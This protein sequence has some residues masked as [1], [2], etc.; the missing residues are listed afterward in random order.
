[1]PSVASFVHFAAPGTDT[2]PPTAPTGLTGQGAI[3]SAT[4][5][6]TASTDNTGVALYN[7]HRSTTS[8]FLPSAPTASASRRRPAFTDT[9]V[10]AGTYFYVVTAQDVAGNVSAPSN[11]AAVHGACR[12]DRAHASTITAPANGATVTG[13]IVAQ[14]HRLR[15]CRRR[16]RAVSA[17]RSAARRRTNHRAVLA[18]LEHAR[19]R[20]TAAH[21]DRASRA[22]RPATPRTATVD[23]VV[24][25]T[26]QTPDRTGGGVRV[27]R[28]QRR[29]GDRRVGPGQHRA[30]FRARRGPRPA[31]SARRCRSTAPVRG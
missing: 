21:A 26:S 15:R 28:G 20:R 30:R 22:T 11:E 19:P 5:T 23:V 24:S 25:N 16:R 31:S 18:R 6:W 4:L 10:A 13:S 1:M 8:G 9:G 7:V 12:H 2:E 29:A 3:G 17:R 14:R 27:Q